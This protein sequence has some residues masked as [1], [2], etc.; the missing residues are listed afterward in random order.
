[1]REKSL[2]LTER[3]FFAIFYIGLFRKIIRSS[4]RQGG[5]TMGSPKSDLFENRE[6]GHKDSNLRGTEKRKIA[7]DPSTRSTLDHF[8]RLADRCVEQGKISPKEYANLVD[9]CGNLKKALFKIGDQRITEREV[10]VKFTTR[11]LRP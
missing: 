4:D 10:P 1:M 3:P 6:H 11:M 7:V 2:L 8:L 5:C 9:L